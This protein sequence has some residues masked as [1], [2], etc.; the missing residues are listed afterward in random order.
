MESGITIFCDGTVK[1]WKRAP[2][3]IRISEDSL[4]LSD[5]QIKKIND[6]L[7]DPVLFSY[8][9]TFSG[10]YNTHLVITKDIQF[11]QITFNAS[12]PPIEM[13]S[14]VLDLIAVIKTIYKK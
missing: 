5:E 14:S 7:K 9:S 13:P 2:N 4:K 8:S 3:S 6:L 11:N 1:F 12:D 10:N